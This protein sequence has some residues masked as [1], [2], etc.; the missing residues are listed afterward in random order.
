ME[1]FY[2]FILEINVYSFFY[3]IFISAVLNSNWSWSSVYFS[4]VPEYKDVVFPLL[5]GRQ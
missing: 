4:I 3:F 5:P 1:F 2:W